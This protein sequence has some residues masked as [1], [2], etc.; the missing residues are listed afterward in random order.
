M[1]KFVSRLLL[2]SALAFAMAPVAQAQTPPPEAEGADTDEGGSDIV[3]IGTRRKDRSIT[4]SS[5]AID[6]ISPESITATAWQNYLF[7]D[8]AHVWNEDPS[9]R[10][11]NP[12][13]LW[14]AGGGIRTVFGSKLQGDF[15]VAVPLQK[16]DL[17]ASR[18]DVRLMFSLTARLLPW[19]F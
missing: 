11:A 5:V 14:S 3:V 15:S 4:D 10:A 18:G 12:D 2:S 17:A 9:R 16:P 1:S 7:T 8:V 6:V 19:S 13:R